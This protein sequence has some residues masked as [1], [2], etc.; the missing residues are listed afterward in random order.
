MSLLANYSVTICGFQVTMGVKLINFKPLLPMKRTMSRRF[1]GWF[2]LVVASA[3]GFGAVA[4]TAVP[5]TF[6]HIT[7]DS[8]FGDWAGV[9]LAYNAPQGPDNAIQYENVYIAND[10]TNLFI[11]LTLYSPRAN[12][13]A[14]SFDNMFID[15]DGNVGTGFS[16]GGI[17]SEML[18]QWGGG[19][20]EKNGT[21]NEGA[22]NNLGWG[23]AGSADSMDFELSISLGATYDSDGTPVFT[24][25]TIAVL[26]EGDDTN[27]TSVEFAV[28]GGL[29]YTLASPP[30]APTNNL[31]L[32]T[33]SGSAWQVNASGTDL[34]TDWLDQ[35]Y[36]DSGTGWTTGNGLFGYTTS[37]GSYPTINT[38][39]S[40]GP[41]TYYFRT[42]FEWANDPANVAFVVT[43]YLSDGAVYYLNGSEVRRVRMPAGAVAYSTAAAAA[44]SPV[45][46]PDVFS[47][48][49]A[50]L[51]GG[52]N[53]MEVE[54][55]Q[56]PG[57]SADMVLGLSLTAA[58]HYP[59]LVVSP[60]LPADQGVL[61]GQSVTFSSDVTGS[62]PLTYQ[63]FFNGTN[64]ISG[65]TGASYTIPLVLDTDAGLYSLAVSNAFSSAATRG[66]LLTVSNIPVS[67]T[68]QP[69]NQIVMEGRPVTFTVGVAGTPLIQYQWSFGNNPITDATNAAYTINSCSL[70]LSLIHI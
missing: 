54:T 62:G 63:W 37:P 68:T 22:I 16:V 33:L 28:N 49:G 2:I 6:K 31:T 32:V 3:F 48:D 15:A 64:A 59:V 23:I 20:Q 27:Y 25:S 50:A 34:G 41:N 45:G 46:H 55:H 14:N 17:G 47:V 70:T 24:N 61:A 53:I 38:V 18:I 40:S 19:Y 12:A 58:I 66:A 8:S 57:S 39:L 10:Q 13:F 42:H 4:Q 52:D 21:F 7:V 43:N 36:D 9:P 5:G 30:T 69:A 26:L 35:A 11:R 67:I 65:A 44:N 60:N 29:V 51:L 56:A 1:L